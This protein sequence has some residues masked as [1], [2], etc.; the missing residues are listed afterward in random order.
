MFPAAPPA[1][2]LYFLKV[3]LVDDDAFVRIM[4]FFFFFF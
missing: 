3:D 1:I 4:G 2:G